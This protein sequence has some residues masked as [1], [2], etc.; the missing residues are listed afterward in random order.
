MF[1]L[2]L[3]WLKRQNSATILLSMQNGDGWKF[4]CPDYELTIEKGI[5][6]GN[7]NKTNKNENIYISGIAE[8]ENLI[9]NWSFEKIS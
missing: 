4:T 1:I 2:K 9:I 8:R 6:L 3:K 5:Y 7:K